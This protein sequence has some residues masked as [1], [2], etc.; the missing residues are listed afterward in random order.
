MHEKFNYFTKLQDTV[1]NLSILSDIFENQ[2]G[3]SIDKYL[4]PNTNFNDQ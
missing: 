2:M 4:E 1:R 3:V